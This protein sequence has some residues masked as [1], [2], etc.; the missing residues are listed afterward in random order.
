MAFYVLAAV[1]V[2]L[3][4]LR[5]LI[6]A[7]IAG[8]VAHHSMMLPWYF[9]QFFS[10]YGNFLAGIMAYLTYQ[11][12]SRFGVVIPVLICAALFFVLPFGRATYPIPLYFALIAFLNIPAKSQIGV[13][14]GDASYSIYLI[15]PLVFAF[16]YIRLQPPLPPEWMQEPLR[17][18]AMAATCLIGLLSWR[19]YEKPMMRL[20]DSIIGFVAGWWAARRQ[21]A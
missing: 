14:L 4:G 12:A 9:E 10:Y 5:G 8:L 16:I 7:L 21:P 3:F 1:T 13:A 20:G 17:F 11:R 6:A 15:H 2:P 19:L 18:G